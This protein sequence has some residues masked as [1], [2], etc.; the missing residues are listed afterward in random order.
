MPSPVVFKEKAE[1]RI[2]IEEIVNEFKRLMPNL[3]V[4]LQKLIYVEEKLC[5]PLLLCDTQRL[6]SYFKDALPIF[7]Y[8]FISIWSPVSYEFL[9]KIE[10]EGGM[11]KL[12]KL[13]DLEK[14]LFEKMKGVIEDSANR[15]GVNP[16]LV[17][18]AY[19]ALINYDLWLADALKDVGL[20]GLIERLTK[21]ASKILGGFSISLYSLIYLVMSI[22]LALFNG[23]PYKEDTLKTLVEWSSSY[24]KEIEDYL[25]AFIFLIPD[26]KYEATRD[27]IEDDVHEGL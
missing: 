25:D 11:S 17:L 8:H 20:N 9:T 24:A 16:E 13:K 26:E 27:L 7:T 18:K 19:A 14:K 3:D 15:K 22:K 4:V 5:K 12:E 2:D 6:A 10:E 21:R 1:R 23:E